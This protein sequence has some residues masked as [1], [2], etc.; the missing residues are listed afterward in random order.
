MTDE[1]FKV[2]CK[3]CLACEGNEET[4]YWCDHWSTDI[5]EVTKAFCS[6]FTPH[7]IDTKGEENDEER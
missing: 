1:R 6:E 2:M 4:G 3:H 5:F 7:P